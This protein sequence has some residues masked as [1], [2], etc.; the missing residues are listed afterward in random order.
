MSF[1]TR[2]MLSRLSSTSMA[3]RCFSAASIESNADFVQP[4]PLSALTEDETMFRES[5]RKFAVEQVAPKVKAMDQASEM[6]QEVI[7]G[8]FENGFLGVETPAE[9]GG[10]GSSFMSACLVVEELAKVDPAVSV[11]CDVHNTIINNMFRFWASDQLKSEYTHR[12]AT[13]MLGSFCLSESGSGSDAFALKTRADISSDESYYTINGQKMWIT[14]AEWAGVFLVMA[15]VDTSKGYKGI[16]CFVVDRDT[17]GLS[18]G[19]PEDKLGI[20]ASSTCNVT[21]EDV[22]VPADRI[23]GEVGKGYKYAIEILNEGR[24]GIGAQMV[25]LAQGAFDCTMPY[26]RQ[27]TQFNTPIGD[28]QGMEHQYAQAATE[29]ECARLLCYNAARLKE[30]GMPFIKE[31]AMAKLYSSQ[32]ANRTASQCI[33]WL[34]GVGF[35]KDHPA[36]K[37]YRDCK[38][39]TIYEGTSNIQLSTIAKLIKENY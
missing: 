37:F 11:M 39:G 24:I 3:K 25:G 20:R 19:K 9:Y 1:L 6:D 18:I 30:N 26:L 8:M 34:G 16:T 33:E 17:P 31:A 28:F 22:K 12:L 38:V 23:L 7:R 15:N 2:Q 10:A 36:E 13:E 14:N 29:I 5:V 32:V 35:T 27:R 4:G 21:L